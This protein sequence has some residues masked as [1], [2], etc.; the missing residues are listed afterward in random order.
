MITSTIENSHNVKFFE[1][2][3]FSQFASAFKNFITKSYE[4]SCRLITRLIVDL[5]S[6]K[7][8]EFLSATLDKTEFMNITSFEEKISTKN[9]TIILLQVTAFYRA[10]L[11][12]VNEAFKT[13]HDVDDSRVRFFLK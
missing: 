2:L 10:Y 1:I 13:L 7:I 9:N 11:N 6:V 3:T 4:I 8:Q 5:S 12:Q